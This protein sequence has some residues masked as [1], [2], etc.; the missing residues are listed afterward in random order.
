M[1][2]LILKTIMK[3]KLRTVAGQKKYWIC[4][5][6]NISYYSIQNNVLSMHQIETVEP[7][8]LANTIT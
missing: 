8:I 1:M 2:K 5:E 6:K 7:N 3:Y 4:H